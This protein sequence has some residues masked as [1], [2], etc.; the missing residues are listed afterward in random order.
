MPKG[1]GDSFTGSDRVLIQPGDL[2]V[3]LRLKITAASGSTKNDGATPYGSTLVSSSAVAHFAQTGASATTTLIS[4]VGQ[5]SQT[6][7]VYLSYSTGLSMGVY[8]VTAKGT[9][10]VSGSTS[11]FVREFDFNRVLV[12]DR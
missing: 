5:S 4:S 6:I 8:N 12:R 11:T 9:F 3:P 10:S 7:L 1:A 2:R